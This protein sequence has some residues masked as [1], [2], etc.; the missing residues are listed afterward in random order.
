MVAAEEEEFQGTPTSRSNER[1]QRCKRSSSTTSTLTS[2][3]KKSKSPMVKIVKDI[4]STFKESVVANTK[5]MQKRANEKAAFSVKRCQQL[6]FECGIEQ[7]V[8]SIYAM[9]KMFETEYQREFFCGLLSHELRLGYFKKWCRD[10][11][12]E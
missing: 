6:A 12:L 11:N 2:P 1:S 9:S 4:A 10:N 3:L 5:Q 7:T 8:D